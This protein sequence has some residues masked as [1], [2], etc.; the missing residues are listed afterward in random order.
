MQIFSMQLHKSG[1][2]S[3]SLQEQTKK[4]V[5]L[6]NT[7]HKSVKIEENSKQLHL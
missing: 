3:H 6:L 4:K 7:K 1:S 5:L 2:C